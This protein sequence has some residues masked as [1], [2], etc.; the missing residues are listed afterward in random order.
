MSDDTTPNDGRS[1]ENT[2]HANAVTLERG[3]EA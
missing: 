2:R 3:W 1:T